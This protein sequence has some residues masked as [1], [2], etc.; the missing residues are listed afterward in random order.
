MELTRE[1]TVTGSRAYWENENI[2]IPG[3]KILLEAFITSIQ[4]REASV[5]KWE[6]STT[7]NNYYLKGFCHLKNQRQIGYH[8]L[9]SDTTCFN[10]TDGGNHMPCFV[11]AGR[12]KFHKMV[13]FPS[14]AQTINSYNGEANTQTLQLLR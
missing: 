3:K 6:S 8:E 14:P 9:Q 10:I 7:Q 13:E 5:I 11:D 2:L 12:W 1:I 4:N